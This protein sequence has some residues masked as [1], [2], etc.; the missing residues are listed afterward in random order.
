MNLLLFKIHKSQ[1]KNSQSLLQLIRHGESE[2]LEFKEA[3]G[4]HVFET[5]CAFGNSRGGTILIGV[6]DRGELKGISAGKEILKDWANQISQVTGLHPSFQMIAIHQ[7]T[8]VV[9]RVNESRIKPVMF[10][11]KAYERS[12][13]TT[14]QMSFEELTRLALTNVGATWD[15]IPEIRA[16]LSD[17][18][19]LKIKRFV[20]MA[21]VEG[22]RRIPIEMATEQVLKKLDLMREGKPTRAAVLLFGKR[23]QKFYPQAVVKVGRFRNETLIVDDREIEGSLFDQVDGAIGYFREKLDT[24]FVMTGKP[25]RDV[26]WEYPLEALRESVTNAVCHRDYLSNAHTQVRIYDDKLLVMNPGELPK[27]LSIGDLRREHDS[28]PRN[29]L[30]AQIFYYAGLIEKWGSGINKMM[31]ECRLAKMPEPRFESAT[32]GFRVSFLKHP[33]STHQV[34]IKHPSSKPKEPLLPEKEQLLQFCS[35]PRTIK[36]ILHH[37]QLKD[38]VHLTRKYLRPLLRKG[39]LSMIDPHSPK[40][41]KQ[42]YVTTKIQD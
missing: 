12:G 20:S 40:N 27:E 15:E 19:S 39:D 1:I 16:H 4:K 14:R 18:S 22:R 21:N 10:H 28:F 6:N 37:F 30:I 25:A 38:R 36:E 17:L 24:M 23:P 34:P 26:V 2:T 35:N 11:G 9:I 8:I 41:P 31:D 33:S 3:F 32:A 13:S 42:K 5:V 7:K 29:R